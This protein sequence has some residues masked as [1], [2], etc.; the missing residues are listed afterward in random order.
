VVIAT[1]AAAA[2]AVVIIV[3]GHGETAFS[4]YYDSG[5]SLAAAGM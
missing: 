1:A 4:S 2:A 5:D 3:L